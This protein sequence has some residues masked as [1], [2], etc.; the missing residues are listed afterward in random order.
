[1]VGPCSIH[2]PVAALEYA[3]ELAKMRLKH[4]ADLVVVMRVYFEKPRTTVGWKGLI[5]DPELNATHRVEDGLRKARSLLLAI[6]E[7]GLPCA[8]E[9]LDPFSPHFYASRFCFRA[10]RLL[11]C[12]PRVFPSSYTSECF[13]RNA[14]QYFARTLNSRC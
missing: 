8:T 11:L 14:C 12:W 2:D 7:L 3:R 1:M 13:V 5:N 10:R 6:N 9:F 4:A